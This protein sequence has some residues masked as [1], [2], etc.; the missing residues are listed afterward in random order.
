MLL[1][2]YGR[3]FLTN[4]LTSHRCI[5]LLGSVQSGQELLL[6]MR[7]AHAQMRRAPDGLPQVSRYTLWVVLRDAGWR[8]QRNRSWCPTGTAVRR[9]KTGPVTVHDPATTPKKT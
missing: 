9:R 4:E 3:Y 8:W 5:Y 7:K 1:R 2:E 6:T